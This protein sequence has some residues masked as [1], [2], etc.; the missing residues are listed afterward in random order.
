KI[1]YIFRHGDTPHNEDADTWGKSVAWRYLSGLQKNFDPQITQTGVA[2]ATLASQYLSG[3]MRTESAPR[4]VTIY[5]SPLRRC[6][7]T[8]MHMIKHAGLDHPNP[9][10]RWPPLKLLVKE[11]LREWMGYGHGHNSDRH[12]SRADIQ[13][14]VEQLQ[15]T[16][17]LN[18]SYHLDVP[19]QENL[20]D[21]TYTDVDQRVCGVLNDIFDDASSGPYVMLVLHGRSNKSFLRVL[22]H[23]PAHVDNFEMSNCAILP[24]RVTR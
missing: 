18:I 8:S 6:I 12:G 10:G 20:H 24:Y 4:P 9:D 19:E 5:T 13:A 2:N 15:V 14:L 23:Q 11:G 22:G 7:E 21:E 3:M 1:I 16:L 17:G